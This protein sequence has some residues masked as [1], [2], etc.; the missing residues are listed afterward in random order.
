GQ[1]HVILA[2]GIYYLQGGGFSVSGQASVTDNGQGVLL[3]NAPGRG[4]DGISVSGK[5]S[6]SLSGLTAGQL[7]GLGPTA[8]QDAALQGL[9]IFQDPGSAAAISVS[10]QASVNIT[11]TIYA[12]G[13]A[14]NVSGSLNLQGDATKKFAAHLIAADLS[15]SGNG[16]VNVDASNN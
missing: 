14:V 9:A 1:A 6:V 12:A 5:A 15:V 7:A 8:P 3:Y 2:P 10:G 16:T 11:G 13:A 4:G